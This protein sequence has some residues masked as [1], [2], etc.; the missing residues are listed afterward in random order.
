MPPKQMKRCWRGV[1]DRGIKCLFGW[2]ALLWLYI[3][4]F[5]FSFEGGDAARM[6][7]RCGGPGKSVELG[8]MM[9][10]YQR[11]NKEV[12]FKKKRRKENALTHGIKIYLKPTGL[13][14]KILLV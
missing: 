2:F 11:V 7:G 8:C 1:K 14:K 9:L 5:Y 4:Y 6:K 13:L 10:N 12:M 3:F